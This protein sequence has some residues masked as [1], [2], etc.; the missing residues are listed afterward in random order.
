MFKYLVNSVM[1]FKLYSQIS[2]FVSHETIPIGFNFC[3]CIR[4][5][6]MERSTYLVQVHK[7]LLLK[8]YCVSLSECVP[9]SGTLL[10]EN[11]F[12]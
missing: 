2:K 12:V 6:A 1:S 5:Q 11:I 9:V 3:G 10:S 8:L 7:S 4:H